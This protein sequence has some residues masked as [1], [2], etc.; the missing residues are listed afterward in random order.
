MESSEIQRL[1]LK[2]QQL[3]QIY[4]VEQLQVQNVAGLLSAQQGKLGKTKQRF[5]DV[6]NKINSA[7]PFG[8]AKLDATSSALR[9]DPNSAASSLVLSAA[10]ILKLQATLASEA[11]K[12][13]LQSADISLTKSWLN[14][15]LIDLNTL[16]SRVEKLGEIS[17][18]EKLKL[19]EI[20]EEGALEELVND[21]AVLSLN[22]ARLSEQQNLAAINNLSSYDQ[23]GINLQSSR[24]DNQAQSQINSQMNSQINNAH[25]QTDSQS[26]KESES[27]AWQH[28]SHGEGNSNATQKQQIESLKLLHSIENSE[29]T[30]VE[31][32]LTD[33]T[34]GESLLS[35]S[36]RHG[37]LQHVNIKSTAAALERAQL[38]QRIH[39]LLHQHGYAS[40]NI[41]VKGFR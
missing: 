10:E 12:V 3:K 33:S 23:C 5:E 17:E 37:E 24:S 7:V 41:L 26:N 1:E 27:R 34:G 25:A 38:K 13:E 11:K 36:A 21:R 30:E 4:L 16:K 29:R 8:N 14:E 40:A 28:S 6:K 19:Q 31:L 15:G 9:A 32:S 20:K 35:L 2:A 22:E 18:F 39:E